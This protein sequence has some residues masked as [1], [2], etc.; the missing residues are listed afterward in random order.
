MTKSAPPSPNGVAS[1]FETRFPPPLVMLVTAALMWCSHHWLR[2]ADL[3]PTGWRLMSIVVALSGVSTV[4]IAF[5]QFQRAKTTINPLDPSQA[6]HIVSTGIFGLSRNPMYVGFSLLLAAWAI[7]LGSV[8]PWFF[9]I[10]FVAYMTRFQ[11]LPE[12][13]ALEQKFGSEY[14]AYKKNVARWVGV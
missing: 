13:L 11:I 14:L 5:R 8:S 1:F 6:S 2:I 10:G 7:F 9:V 4:V 12:E 3:I